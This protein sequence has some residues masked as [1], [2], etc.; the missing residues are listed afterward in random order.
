MYKVVWDTLLPALGPERLV[1]I[2]IRVIEIRKGEAPDRQGQQQQQEQLTHDTSH[3]EEIKMQRLQGH[4]GAGAAFGSLR[5]TS[6]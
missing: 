6:C 2:L 1:A 4:G 3:G 5:W